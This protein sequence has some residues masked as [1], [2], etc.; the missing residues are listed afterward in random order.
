MRCNICCHMSVRLSVR[1][2]FLVNRR[3]ECGACFAVNLCKAHTSNVIRH[4]IQATPIKYIV[5]VY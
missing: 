3:S 1:F 4:V 2:I 5:E